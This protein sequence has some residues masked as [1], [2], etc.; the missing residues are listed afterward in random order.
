MELKKTLFTGAA[1]ALLATGAQ[2]EGELNIYS[3][4]GQFSP[5]LIEKF[6]ARTGIEVTVDGYISN[7]AL[8]TKLQAGSSGYDMATP[9]QHFV[10]IMADEGLLE[11]VDMHE[12][13]AFDRVDERWVGQWWDPN[14]DYSIPV[15]YGT[16]GFA[17]NRDV[18][19]GP[20]DSWSVYF[21]PPPE[22]QGKVASLASAD[23]VIGAAQ[24]YLGVEFCTEDPQ[25]MKKVL[26]LLEAQK[27]HVAAY[28]SDNI[29]NRIASGDVG[30]HF[31]WGGEA[32]GARQAGANLEYAAPKEGLVGWL[33]SI[34]VPKGAT[35]IENVKTFVNFLSKPENAT[36]Q[37]NYYGYA[38]PFELIESRMEHNEDNAP[39][40]FMDVPVKFS[41]ACSPRAQELVTRVWTQLMQ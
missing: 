37:Y 41:R 24:L 6:E 12:L 4:S 15:D 20:V 7:E 17:V 2:A 11:D 30:A 9:S 26:D 29:G 8:L 14:N 38:S 35:N 13:E 31:W 28:A 1:A 39:E 33:D 21:E 27:P 10:K 3:W 32:M 16:A 22:L 40:L 5:E 23:E 18:Y 34:V 19:D 25:E 36:L